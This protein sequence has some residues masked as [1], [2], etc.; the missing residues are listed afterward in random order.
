MYHN[1]TYFYYD[2]SYVLFFISSCVSTLFPLIIILFLTASIVSHHI[3]MMPT[4]YHLTYGLVT[5]T[6]YLF[7]TLLDHYLY[8]YYSSPTSSLHNNLLY[9]VTIGGCTFSVS[10]SVPA[11]SNF[12]SLRHTD[13][14]I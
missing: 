1:E 11:L 8:V 3:Y 4:A 5:Y 6:T 13:V 12:G 14:T 2:I 10:R 9:N 7:L